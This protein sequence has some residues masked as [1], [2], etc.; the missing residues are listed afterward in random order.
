MK[1]TDN[2]PTFVCLETETVVTGQ[3]D[4]NAEPGNPNGYY[5]ACRW[6]AALQLNDGEVYRHFHLWDDKE[7]ALKFVTKV[8]LACAKGKTLNMKHWHYNRMAYGSKAFR[9]RGGEEELMALERAEMVDE[10][11]HW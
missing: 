9:E 3:N 8:R 11:G 10:L 4:E 7:V 6:M 2:A 5:Y 1:A